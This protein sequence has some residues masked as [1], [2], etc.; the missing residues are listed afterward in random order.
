[1]L[2]ALDVWGPLHMNPVTGM[3]WL[4][5][6]ILSSVH[7]ENFSLVT[8]MNSGDAIIQAWNV[9]TTP[10]ENWWRIFRSYYLYK[11]QDYRIF[12]STTKR[13]YYEQE[14]TRKES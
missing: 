10:A 14:N 6:W 8:E 1:M 11:P 9:T 3:A 5:E 12:T 4:G 13:N 2:D 7:M